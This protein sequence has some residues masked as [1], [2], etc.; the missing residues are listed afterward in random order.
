M[1]AE[2]RNEIELND[3]RGCQRLLTKGRWLGSYESPSRSVLNNWQP[4][5][6]MLH[7]YK[8][9]D[10]TTCLAARKVTFIGD[11][12]IRQIYWALTRKLDAQVT[13]DRN[14]APKLHDDLTFHTADVTV[15]FVWDPFLNST[16]LNRHLLGL[17]HA[18]DDTSLAE[19]STTPAIPILLVGGGLWHARHLGPESLKQFRRSIDRIALGLSPATAITLLPTSWDQPD[20]N[21]VVLAPVQPP[22]YN[23]LSVSRA[24]SMTPIKVEALNSY[25]RQLPAH[26]LSHVAWSFT[27]MTHERNSTFDKDG[28]HVVESVARQ[29]ADVL[30]N[31]G[32]NSLLHQ[33]QGYPFDKTCCSTYPKLRWIQKSMLIGAPG[34]LGTLHFKAPK[35]S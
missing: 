15:E 30:L 32:C 27:E 22:L 28:L 10:I 19:R 4:A 18:I 1:L 8:A 34:L 29:K 35:G 7:E 11:S 24:I 12:T 2:Q 13:G 9:G 5:G 16:A 3:P 23:R 25:L 26:Q 14:P 21:L 31:L 6:C 33:K 17:R 20:R